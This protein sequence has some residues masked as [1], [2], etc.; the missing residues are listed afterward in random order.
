ME[1]KQLRLDRLFKRSGRCLLV[2]MDHGVTLGAVGGLKEIRQVV[3]GVKA[4]GADGVVVHKGIARQVIPD[5]QGGG[6]ELILHLSASTALARDPLRK[7]LVAWPEE[8]IQLGATAVSVHVNLG[9]PAEAEMLRDLGRVAA[10]CQSWGLPLLAMAYVR[11]GSKESEFDPDKIAHAARVAEELG[12][13]VVKVNYTGSP[14]SFARVV[15]SVSLPVVIA[16]G[17]KTSSPGELL[18][19]VS[20]ALRAGAKGVAVGRYIFDDPDPE[21][22]TRALRRLLDWPL[23]DVDRLAGELAAGTLGRAGE[24]P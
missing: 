23:L 19:A 18:H 4:G 8:A 3:R 24:A 21:R 12:A 10:E 16:G 22:M 15:S 2:P 11:D 17:A 6:C 9:S 13:D 7:E 20:G 14:E 1:G 5:L